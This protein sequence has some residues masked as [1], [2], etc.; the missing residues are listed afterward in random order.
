MILRWNNSMYAEY[1]MTFWDVMDW[2]GGWNSVLARQKIFNNLYTAN[3]DV[4]NILMEAFLYREIG[5]EIVERFVHEF[6]EQF[7]RNLPEYLIRKKMWEELQKDTE[8]LYNGGED[9]SR[10]LSDTLDGNKNDIQSGSDSNTAHQETKSSSTA[11]QNSWG[12]TTTDQKINTNNNMIHSDTPGNNLDWSKNYAD[13]A[14]KD[15]GSQ[16]TDESVITNNNTT[17]NTSNTA[18]GDSTSQINYGKKNEQIT[19]NKRD[20]N[21]TI[22]KRMLSGKSKFQIYELFTATTPEKWFIKQFDKQFMLIFG[23]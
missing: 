16:S 3:Q 10:L 17:S 4:C 1:T 18:S 7:T 6:G 15:N 11:N 2:L 20:V 13:V 22:K 14:Q 19:N 21:E 8:L 9:I 5:Y 12:T 23:G